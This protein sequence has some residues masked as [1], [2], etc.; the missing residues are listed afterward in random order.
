MRY[1]NAYDYQG[2]HLPRQQ[3]V[4]WQLVLIDHIQDSDKAL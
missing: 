1:A 3:Y 2:H 4:E